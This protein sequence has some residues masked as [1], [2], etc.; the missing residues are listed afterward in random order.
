MNWGINRV[1]SIGIRMF[2]DKWDKMP[3]KKQKRIDRKLRKTANHF[4]N[5]KVKNPSI[6]SVFMYHVSKFVIRRYVG[7]GNYPFEYW[8]EQGY[9]AKRP[10]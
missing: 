3:A 7:E 1:Y 4:L 5:A 6:S 8:K 2:T 9:F 10:F